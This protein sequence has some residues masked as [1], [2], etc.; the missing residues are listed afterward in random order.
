[1]WQHDSGLAELGGQGGNWPPQIFKDEVKWWF[2]GMIILE[3]VFYYWPLQNFVPSADPVLS[4][5]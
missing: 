2:A 1:M 5:G 3:K 4:S